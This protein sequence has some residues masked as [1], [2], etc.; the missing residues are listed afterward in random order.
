MGGDQCAFGAIAIAAGADGNEE[1]SLVTGTIT[2]AFD[3]PIL[4]AT[5]Y[6]RPAVV[7]VLLNAGADVNATGAV[8]DDGNDIVYAN[9][10]V[11]DY[12]VRNT[13]NSNIP[14]LVSLFV[15]RGVSVN[16][17]TSGNDVALITPLDRF[18]IDM[19]HPMIIIIGLP[20][21][22]SERPAA[23]VFFLV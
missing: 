20:P 12:V 22:L 3:S 7:S 6:A 2:Y 17:R 14:S 8:F 21:I 4:A 5:R 15:D 11:L 23:S 1:F 16:L 10:G 9:I 13:A 18:N 19:P